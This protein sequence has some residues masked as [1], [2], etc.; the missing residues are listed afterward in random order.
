[1]ATNFR[2]QTNGLTR[3]NAVATAAEP[4]RR[5]EWAAG[6]PALLGAAI[7]LASG[8][9]MF[10]PTACWF[11]ASL[12]QEF[13]WTRLQ[14]S[15]AQSLGLVGSVLGPG[16]GLLI[17]WIGL[18]YVALASTLLLCLAYLVLSTMNGS[19]LLFGALCM[20]LSIA[21]S[22]TSGIVY[23]RVVTSWFDHSRGLA[24]SVSRA[25][26]AILGT[27]VPIALYRVIDAHGWRAGYWMLASVTAAL[28]IPAILFLVREPGPQRSESAPRSMEPRAGRRDKIRIAELLRNPRLWRLL[29]VAFFLNIPIFG[30]MV[31][32]QPLLTS[33]QMTGPVAAS[34]IG[35]FSAMILVGTFVSGV[36][37]D[38][39]GPR[40]VGAIFLG[41][42]I[43]GFIALA[44]IATGPTGAAAA[45]LLVGIN[46]GVEND[47]LAFL[48]A[49][50]FGRVG[51]SPVYGLTIVAIALAGALGAAAFGAL[52]DYTGSYDAALWVGSASLLGAVAALLTGGRSRL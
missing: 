42:A 6:W 49:R 41:C 14:I 22:G 50:Q 2:D 9:G 29:L 4:D 28:G 12:H 43:T 23:S 33:H 19:L 16:I 35:A 27:L 44:T 21:S 34:V 51:F 38:R 45:V 5:G 24:L 25:G 47:L 36:L 32:L 11:V 1:M 3:E 15:S 39:Y 40:L 20:L 17:N 13:G 52:R 8:S 26:P 18:R 7:G 48:I 30:L 46:Q 10:A 37:M 31:H